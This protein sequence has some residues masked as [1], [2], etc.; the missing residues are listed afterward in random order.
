MKKKNVFIITARIANDVHRTSPT[1]KKMVTFGIA[2]SKKKDD[3]SF[4]NVW[5]YCIA[6]CDELLS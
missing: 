6:F 2:I 5:I 1:G 3:G 4:A